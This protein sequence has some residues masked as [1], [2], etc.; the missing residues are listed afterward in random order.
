MQ[1]PDFPT[2]SSPRARLHPLGEADTGALYARACDP[3][4]GAWPR[5]SLQGPPSPAQFAERLWAGVLAQ[6]LVIDPTNAAVGL[7][8]VFRADLHSR[9]AW[10]DDVSLVPEGIPAVDRSQEAL[11]E[12]LR[13]LVEYSFRTWSLRK[14]YYTEIDGSPT[15]VG[16][17]G[18]GTVEA[19]FTDDVL[20]R[21]EYVTRTVSAIYRDDW[22]L[23]C[24]IT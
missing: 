18:V 20:L 9:T 10:V 2:L 17:L 16:A 15:N 22:P 3:D 5:I 13:L 24:E 1:Q 14:L 11:V 12:G 21:G 4:F 19:R 7:V 6:Y 8:A 23:R